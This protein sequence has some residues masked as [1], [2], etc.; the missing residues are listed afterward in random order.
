MINRILGLMLMSGVIAVT[1]A[2]PAVQA[3]EQGGD[4]QDPQSIV[5]SW[6][7]I[8]ETGEHWL[9]SFTSDGIALN[10]VQSEVSV[11]RPIGVLTPAHGVW[12]RAGNR[13]F[14][15]TEKAVFYDI[16]TGAFISTGKLR[17]VLTLNK[18]GDELSGNLAVDVVGLD[19]QVAFTLTHTL[20]FTRIQVE[21]AD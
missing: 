16:Q 10:S 17:G 18:A 4:E 5:G 15:I 1:V 6:I 13:K 20:S 14:A 19:G 2:T 9:T 21:A 8:N 12:A 3:A 11:T 7:G